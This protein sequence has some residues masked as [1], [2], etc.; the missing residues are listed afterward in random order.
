MLQFTFAGFEIQH[1][2]SSENLLTITACAL[3]PTSTCPSCSHASNHVHSYYTR[4]PQDLPISGRRVQLVLRV[5][6]FR[7]PNPQ[8]QKQTFAERL[9]NL[10]VSARQTS[11]LGMILESLAIVL[12]GQVG[13][14]LADQ[15]AMPVSADTLLRRAKKKTSTLPTPRVLGV[16]DFAFRRGHTYGTILID[17][18][19]HQPVDLLEDRRAETLAQWLRQHPG[20]EIIS[21]DRSRDYQRGATDGAPQA[22]QVID[23]WHLL[24]NLREAIERFLSHTPMPE[25]ASEDAGL[26]ERRQ[27]RTSGERVRSQG[28]RELRLALYQQVIALYQHG[29]TILGIAKQLHISPRRVCTFV[30]SASFPEW[31]KPARTRSAIDPYRPYLQ[32]RWQQGCHATNQLWHEVQARGFS[33]SYMMV[34]RWVQLQGDGKLETLAHPQ[35]QATPL[36]TKMAPRHLAWLFLRNFEHLEQQEQQ[37][38]SLIRKTPKIEVA[39]GLAQQF[40]TLLK[41]RNAQ[42]LETWLQ[43]CQMSGISDFVTFAQALHIEGSAL[44]AAFT[45]PYS[46]DHVA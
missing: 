30:R 19:T 17:L 25:E 26:V 4:S 13:S 42:P 43:D 44:H 37:T 15:L 18:E 10:P 2:A 33:G 9:P 11:R 34:Y 35:D 8:C 22:Q 29:G 41:E 16:D 7:C 38:L 1:T 31:G 32:E 27:K 3:L 20:V 6:R 24:K 36:A 39:Y 40:L 45:L 46:N 21:R 14:R 23:R 28:S 12:S 5:R